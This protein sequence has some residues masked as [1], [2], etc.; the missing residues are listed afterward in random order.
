L[1]ILL[2]DVILSNSKAGLHAYQINSTKAK[3]IYNGVRSER[4]QQ[5]FDTRKVR[6]ELGVKTDYLVIMVA[7]FSK[8]KD[9]DLF[10]NVAKEIWK[11]RDDTTFIAIGDGSDF[12]RIQQRIN[13]EQIDNILLT[14]KQKEVERF[15]AASDIGLLCTYSEGISNSI[16]EYM[17]L[18]KPVISTDINGGSSEII[19]EGE[20]GYCTERNTEKVVTAINFLLNDEKLRE[21]MGNRGRERIHSHFSI[22]KFG[23]EFEIVY[24]EVLARKKG[25]KAK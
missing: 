3:V 1:N 22:D 21:S 5:H 23:N 4:F 11:I 20:T 17:S 10:I 24:K 14:G 12:K 15:I 7:S 6:K 16:I 18:G 25:I 8:Y 9:Y 2:S 19:I 13:D